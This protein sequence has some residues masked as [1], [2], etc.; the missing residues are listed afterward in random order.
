MK[1]YY[2]D[3]SCTI[4]NCDCREVLPELDPVDLVLTDPPFSN[5]T[6]DNAKSNRGKGHGNKAIDFQAIDFLFS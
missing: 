5:T 3:E 4:Y 2:K 6:H 1:P